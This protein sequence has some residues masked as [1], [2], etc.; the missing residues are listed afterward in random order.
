VVAN[1]LRSL[2]KAD[3]AHAAPVILAHMDM[4][5]HGNVIA[6]AALASLPSVDTVAALR[7]ALTRANYG[8]PPAVRMAA[9]GILSRYGRGNSEVQKLYASTLGERRFFMRG[10]AVRWLGDNGDAS[11][12]PALQKLVDANEERLVEPAK[13]AIEKIRKRMEKQ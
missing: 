6:S 12:L 5:S 7:T 11:V 10:Q 8:Q 3:S 2:A 13:A 9:F 1:A 4:P